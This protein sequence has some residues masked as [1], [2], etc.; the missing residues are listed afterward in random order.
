[1]SKIPEGATHTAPDKTY[2]MFAN[3]LWWA[4][5][6]GDWIVVEGAAPQH[7]MSIQADTKWT[8][9]G[10]P[11][12]GLVCEHSCDDNKTDS[13]DGGWKE[14]KIVGHHQFLND[15]YLCAVWVSG[16][17]VSYSSEGEH[18]RPIRT[19]EQIE[20]EKR[21]DAIKEMQRLVGS[22]NTSPFAELY[23]FGYRLQVEK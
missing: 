21:A 4:Y 11:P 18:F 9:E 10:L 2:R 15:E 22:C 23:D 3:G 7:Y 20:S 13:P 16:T 17:E 12:V 8:G 19:P 6:D 14:V 5:A 1:M